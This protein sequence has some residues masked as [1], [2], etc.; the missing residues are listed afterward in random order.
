MA[1][2]Q[3]TTIVPS[4]VRARRGWVFALLAALAPASQVS[5]QTDGNGD[6][7]PTLQA[8]HIEPG[9]GI[10]LD[11][12]ID[13]PVWRR[14]TPA[15]GFLQRDP[16]QGEP[17]TER[18][19][20]F[21]V[22]DASNL[23]IGA[24]LYD[25]DPDGILAYQK[26]RDASLGTDD[27]FMWI[28]DTFLDQRT[29]YF[30]EINPAGL[31]GDGLIGG[32]G[33]GGFGRG[34][35]R[36]GGAF[37][38]NKSW[39]GIWEARVVRRLDGWSAE[40]R[41]PFRTLNFD[42]SNDTW[43][44][45]FQRTVRRKNE[46]MLWTGHRRNQQLTRPVFAGRLTGLKGMS[47]GMGLEAKPYAVAGWRNTPTTDPGIDPTDFP[48][49]AGLDFSYNITSSIR[50]AA[51]I[52]TDFAEVE[53]DQRRTNLTRFAQFFPE[54]RDFFLEGS[55]VFSFAQR[56][57][58]TPYFSRNIGLTDGEPVPI[59]YGAR[60][61]GQTGR[62][63]LGFVQVR[64]GHETRIDSDGLI[65]Q[66]QAEDFTIAR[67]KRTFMRQSTI[68]AIYT[69]R[70]TAADSTG[71]APLDRHT[72]GADL[73]FYTSRFLGDKNF[74]FEAFAVWN[75]DPERADTSSFWDRSARG[76]RINYPNDLWRISSSYRELDKDF[77]PALGFTRRNGFRRLQPTVSFSPRPRDLLGLR[78]LQWE[79][80]F[81]YLMDMQW[82]LETRKTDFKLLGLR[83]DSGD[84]VDFDVTQLFER[85][86][87]EDEFTI[88]GVT[89]P[90][91]RYNTVSWRASARTA[92]RRIVSVNVELRGGEFWSGTRR[93]Y[94]FGLTAR[95]RPGFSLSSRYERNIIDLP[96]GN[97]TTN[98]V[99]LEGGWHLSPWASLTGDVQYDD[100]SELVGLFAKFR[101]IIRPGN[102]LFLVYTHN[103]DNLGTR[104]QNFDFATRSRGVS[105]KLNYTHRF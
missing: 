104:L 86:E 58:V 37:G 98:L 65:N 48:A 75:S 103:W 2:P 68:G 24:I 63:E 53:V 47:Q 54:R 64:T 42:P 6:E 30:F 21:V 55:G 73:D 7:R 76:I 56:N 89:I 70:G 20:V 18:T 12:N 92:G 90:A 94:E 9:E 16:D 22:Y 105:T 97:F 88:S 3:S 74:Q 49:D 40:I 95:P 50:A 26:Q 8:I 4:K 101:W 13:E 57:G 78:Q 44:I 38:V 29:G 71:F 91:G 31:M 36:G 19:E 99:R 23:Y 60:L 33:G 77:D 5:A 85:L 61:G 46:E 100:D 39:D 80:R 82:N 10:T 1:I 52:N 51:T 28:L 84:R 35:F 34:G 14:A 93:G 72:V 69:R 15:T 81:E 25:S 43:G 66:I 67:V 62:Y 96:E 41:I 79:I 83:F 11:G 102:D 32:G 17:A 27:R 45:N 59:T 87:P